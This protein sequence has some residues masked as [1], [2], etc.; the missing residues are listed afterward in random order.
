MA[1]RH[2][3]LSILGTASGMRLVKVTEFVIQQGFVEALNQ[4]VVNKMAYAR[5]NGPAPT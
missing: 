2:G 5:A 4:C 1:T 3:V